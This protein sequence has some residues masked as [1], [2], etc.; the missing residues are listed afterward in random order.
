MLASL[1]GEELMFK[2]NTPI[3]NAHR[4]NTSQ[5]RRKSSKSGLCWA[6]GLGTLIAGL[7]SLGKPA[8]A[9]NLSISELQSELDLALCLN[10]WPYALAV[11]DPL[12]S[13]PELTPDDRT[14]LVQLRHQL[15]RYATIRAVIPPAPECDAVLAQTIAEDSVRFSSDRPLDWAGSI[16]ALSNEGAPRPSDNPLP[17]RQFPPQVALDRQNEPIPLL[18]PATP[19]DLSIG[20]N[21]AD[22]AVSTGYQTFSFLAGLGD[23]ISL[24]VDVTEVLPGALYTDDDSQ[25][26]LFDHNGRLLAENDDLSG[27]Q[28]SI[29]DFVVPETGYYYAVVTTYNND[30]ILNDEQVIAGWSDNGGSNIEFNLTING[31]PPTA[32][33][34]R[35]TMPQ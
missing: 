7:W 31:V 25:L 12:I 27:V 28:S 10:E 21:V 23:R 18:S 1:A 29:L 30:P 2:W 34:L 35:P 15:Q 20:S 5:N 8:S 22:G 26:F 4:H 19:I 16:Y 17:P 3:N 14:A 13:S 24:E 33:L 11:I 32:R 9:T 6:V